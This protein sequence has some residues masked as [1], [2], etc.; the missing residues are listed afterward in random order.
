[1]FELDLKIGDMIHIKSDNIFSKYEHTYVVLDLWPKDFEV[2]N[3]VEL[4]DC[5][6]EK[7]VF[8]LTGALVSSE[9]LL[10]IFRDDN[11]DS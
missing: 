9:L 4:W 5:E 1:M 3:W 11:D 6:R 8:R 10:R 2:R 7:K